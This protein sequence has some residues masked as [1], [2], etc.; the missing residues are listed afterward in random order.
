MAFEKVSNLGNYYWEPQI[1]LRKQILRVVYCKGQLGLNW[2]V[3]EITN[4]TDAKVIDWEK[5]VN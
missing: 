2:D 4:I 3:T 5:F 1:T